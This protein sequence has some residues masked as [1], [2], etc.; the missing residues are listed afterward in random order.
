MFLA[1][2]INFAVSLLLMFS[3]CSMLLYT[4]LNVSF[5]IQFVLIVVH[6][7]SVFFIEDCEYPKMVAALVGLQGVFML[8]L[9][10]DF[11]QK[12]YMRKKE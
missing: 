12:A 4:I 7:F 1:V 10:Y 6:S 2:I 8:V 11:Y 5:Q 3:V 9:F